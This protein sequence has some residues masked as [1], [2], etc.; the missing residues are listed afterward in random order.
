MQFT[1]LVDVIVMRAK[2]QAVETVMVAGEVIY[3]EGR[4]TRLDRDAILAELAETFARPLTEARRRASGWRMPS[5]R[6]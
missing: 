6:M 1:P 2:A 3:H 5:S 4:F